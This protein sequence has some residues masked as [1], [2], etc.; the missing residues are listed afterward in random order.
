VEGTD[1]AVLEEIVKK[2]GE[3]S[4]EARVEVKGQ[5]PRQGDKQ[6][7]SREVVEQ[8][9]SRFYPTMKNP[10]Y[11]KPSEL[12]EIP[13]PAFLP[14]DNWAPLIL[15]VDPARY[16]DDST[17]LYWR[18]GRR[19]SPI[20]PTILKGA[21]NMEVANMIAGLITKFNPDAVCVDA[22]N[23]TGVIDRLRELG[24]KVHEVWFGAGS[25]EQEYANL[26]TYMWAQIRDWLR[27]GAIPN[28]PDLIDDLTSPEYKFLGTS[29]RIALESKEQ[30][31]KRG[32]SS[33]DRADALACTFAVKV[34]R[35]D[36][37]VSRSHLNPNR[38][39][40]IARDM[41]YNIFGG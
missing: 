26:R 35:K 34:A 3:D 31:K 10:D 39:E 32:Y 30:L 21:D 6:F 24:Y 5:F 13:N 11:G 36:S 16:G 15:G 29:D 28:D 25:P 9:V 12:P 17:V 14:E 4:D 27:G 38:R 40:R 41:D 37:V 19:A 22:G 18:Q 8:A 2:Y 1:K 23:G 33:P 7:I 20:P